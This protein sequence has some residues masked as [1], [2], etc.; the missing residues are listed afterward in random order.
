MVRPCPCCEE[1]AFR[2]LFRFADVPLSGKFRRPEDPPVHRIDLAFE[3]CESCGL[4]RQQSVARPPSYDEVDRATTSQKPAHLGEVPALLERAGVGRDDLILEIGANDG[5]FLD[6]L[7]AAGFRNLA[8]VEPSR[9]LARAAVARG[10]DVATAYFGDAFA[11]QFIRERGKARAIVCRHTLE[12]VPDPYAFVRGIRACLDDER[13]VALVE[14][15][16]GVAIPDLINVYEL[17]DEHLYCFGACS[18]HRLL[19][20]AGLG[21]ESIEPVPHLD[22]RN[23]V[24]WCRAGGDPEASIWSGGAGHD[25]AR[26][27]AFAGMLEA[28]RAAM[29]GAFK[30]APRPVYLI[31]ASHSQSNFANYLEVAGFVDYLIDDDPYKAGRLA[32]LRSDGGS[33]IT[34]AAFLASA[35][36]GTVVRSGFGYP[37]W[38]DKICAHARTAGMSVIDPLDCRPA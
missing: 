20:R 32:P 37:G 38:M 17:W 30:A 10:L 23:L 22:T 34:T 11:T 1:V 8:G 5:A 25:S 3:V 2:D 36:R 26:W 35:T 27:L 29:I 6:A 18:L 9:A 31:G 13:G 33:I 4:V 21:V 15:P 19:A 24:A 16:D 28:Y 14:V 12:H 7:R